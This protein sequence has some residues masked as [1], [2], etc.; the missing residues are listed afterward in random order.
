MCPFTVLLFLSF[1]GGI[2]GFGGGVFCVCVNVLFCFMYFISTCEMDPKKVH[3]KGL[4][5]RVNVSLCIVVFLISAASIIS[6]Y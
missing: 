6:I 2:S 4:V 1:L 3:L 5:L